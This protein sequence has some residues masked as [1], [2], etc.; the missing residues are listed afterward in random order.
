MSAQDMGFMNANRL[1]IASLFCAVVLSCAATI[2]E[3]P[4]PNALDPETRK[5]IERSLNAMTQLDPEV[6]Q[7]Q[8]KKIEEATKIR[9]SLDA[10][11]AYNNGVVSRYTITSSL[12]IDFRLTHLGRSFSVGGLTDERGSPWGVPALPGCS[13]FGSP[14]VES[15]YLIKSGT[16]VRLLH[17]DTFKSP[18]LIRLDLARESPEK[19]AHL[20]YDLRQWTTLYSA[21][22]IE[23]IRN[24]PCY[25]MGRGRVSVEWK[26]AAV[27]T[28]LK[29]VVIES[30]PL[31]KE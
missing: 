31:P 1:T 5:A 11:V 8:L 26:D 24:Y 6:R 13:L 19:P 21:D 25:L 9:G 23:V 28:Q 4:N 10:I 29:S 17:V 30:V 7:A 20:N 16:C 3:S 22:T 27:P 15:T 14:S 2:A 18:R 12:S